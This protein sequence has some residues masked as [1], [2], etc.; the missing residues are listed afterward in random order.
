[1]KKYLR[2]SNTQIKSHL[3]AQR[4]SGLSIT[5]Y[6]RTHNIRPST[7]HLWKSK[8]KGKCND[9]S[10]GGSFVPIKISETIEEHNKMIARLEIRN[11]IN[12]SFYSGCE[13]TFLSEVIKHL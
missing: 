2:L 12:L 7:F 8:H 9:I 1:M 5:S 4:D 11:G 10:S 3:I 6:C 13:P